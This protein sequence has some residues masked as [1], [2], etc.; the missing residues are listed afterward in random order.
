[1]CHLLLA[2]QQHCHVPSLL[3]LLMMMLGTDSSPCSLL[4]LLY[5]WLLG[6]AGAWSR[7]YTLPHLAPWPINC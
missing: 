1:V 6:P 7:F 2:L 5:T 4:L 3:L